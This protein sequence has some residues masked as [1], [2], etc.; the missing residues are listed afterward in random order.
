M[1]RL[2]YAGRY[3]RPLSDFQHKVLP[4]MRYIGSTFAYPFILLLIALQ[5]SM[6]MATMKVLRDSRDASKA[7]HD[8]YIAQD[9]ILLALLKDPSIQ[10]ILKESSLLEATLKTGLEQIRGNRRIESK[11]AEQ[12]F[13]ALSKYAVGK[14]DFLPLHLVFQPSPQI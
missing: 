13:D 7:M 8:L 3:R 14:Y 12:G 9:H 10:P 5:T 4:Q 1:S 11:N 2:P 6:S